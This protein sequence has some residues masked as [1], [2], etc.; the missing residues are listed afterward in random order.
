MVKGGKIEDEAILSELNLNWTQPIMV[1]GTTDKNLPS[2]PDKKPVFLEDLP[3]KGVANDSAGVVQSISN[4]CEFKAA[5]KHKG[6]VVVDFFATWCGPC[7][8]IAPLL[9]KFSEQYPEAKFLKVDVDENRAISQEYEVTSMPT[10]L[11][12]KDGQ[13]VKKI[14]GANPG[15]I[16]AAI[17]GNI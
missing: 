2:K 16:K 6:L 5:L 15:G 7:K 13:V 1:L 3:N 14:V 4:T 12:F 11:F 9:Q 17:L 8:M 10:I